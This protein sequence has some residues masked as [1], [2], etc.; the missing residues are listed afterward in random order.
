MNEI[1]NGIDLLHYALVLMAEFLRDYPPGSFDF[2]ET[3]PQYAGCI[4]GSYD[5]TPDQQT[6]NIIRYFL[7]KARKQ[8]EEL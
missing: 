2:I 3:D 5:E 8:K 4:C 7:E 1:S 6:E